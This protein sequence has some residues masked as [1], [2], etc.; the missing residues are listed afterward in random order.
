[1]KTE[2]D[3]DFVILCL[4][5]Q[6]VKELQSVYDTFVESVELSCRAKLKDDFVSLTKMIDWDLVNIMSGLAFAKE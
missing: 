1:M 3:D 5:D 6:F 4:Y 2:F